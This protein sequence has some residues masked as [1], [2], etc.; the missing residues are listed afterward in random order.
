MLCLMA[1]FLFGIVLLVL[2]KSTPT[3]RLPGHVARLVAAHLVA[4]DRG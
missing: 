4:G 1:L 2:L 3:W